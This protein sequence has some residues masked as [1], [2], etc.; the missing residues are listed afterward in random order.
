MLESELAEVVQNLREV[1]GDLTRVEVKRA[2]G[3]LPSSLRETLSA[4]SNTAGG[5]VILGLDEGT[6]FAATGVDDPAK[7]ASDLASMCATD[8]EPAIR[9]VLQQMKFEDVWLVVAEVPEISPGQK[10]SYVKSRGMNKGS[11]IRVSDGDQLLSTYEVQM[12]LASRGQPLE[13][14]EAVPGSSFGDLD[15]ALVKSL[16]SRVRRSRPYAFSGLDDLGILRQLN[17]LVA[18][19]DGQER[20]S[21]GGLL[22]MGRHPQRFYPQLGMTFVVY[23]TERGPDTSSGVRFL[24]NVTLEGPIPVMARDALAALRRNMKRRSVVAGVGRTDVW[25]YP[26]AALR[27]ALVNALVHRDLSAPSRGT[28][29]QIEMYPD[30]LTV[31][32]PGGLFGPVTIADLTED[33]TSSS[34][35]SF[36]LK[37][38]E[39]V[40]LPGE[41]RAVCENRGS[42]IRTMLEA[43]RAAGMTIPRFEDRISS[44]MVTFPNASLLDDETISWLS[45]LNEQGLTDSQCIGLAVLRTG[46]RLD[47][48]RYRSATGVD[49]RVATAELQDLV[50]REL[51]TPLGSGRWTEY[52]LSSRT[53]IAEIERSRRL[54]PRDRR[55]L[56]LEALGTGSLSRA[57]IDDRTGLGKQVV[58]HW[59]RVLRKEKLV[60]IVGDGSPQSRN[61]RYERTPESWGQNALDFEVLDDD[62]PQS[63]HDHASRGFVGA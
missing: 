12:L 60:R 52:R 36:L 19:E 44:F 30:R 59:L 16:V 55:Q 48:A 43:L 28:Q 10:P 63:E 24:D 1:G 15:E 18:G 20:V 25:D 62:G 6:G 53:R 9:P 37:I 29:V 41:D 46:D 50:R 38:L 54:A 17:V 4:F 3:G 45:R 39:D 35:N 56:V 22:A 42:G 23:P 27:E 61:V 57:E 14:I 21:L 47:N 11:Y 34:R 32:N 13:D 7:M 49:S 8:M 31:R 51:I 33:G 2:A 40:T 5:T 58:I 26:E